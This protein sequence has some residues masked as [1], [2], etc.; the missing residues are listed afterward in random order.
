MNKLIIQFCKKWNIGELSLFGSSLTDKF[1]NDSDIDLLISFNG[2]T[3]YGLFELA[4]MKIELEKIYGRE[5]DLVTRKS[6]E[7]S[8]NHLRSKSILNNLKT[9]YAE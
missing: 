6:V 5:V 7:K 2:N 8:N 1:N 3:H 9:L 4:E